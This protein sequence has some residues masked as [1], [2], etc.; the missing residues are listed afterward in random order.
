MKINDQPNTK[1][2]F[3]RYDLE[4]FSQS[5]QNSKSSSMQETRKKKN[6]RG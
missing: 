1:T 5:S 3:H 4:S 2:I 6:G